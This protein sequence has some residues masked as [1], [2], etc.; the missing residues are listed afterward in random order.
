MLNA[1]D[2]ADSGIECGC[3]GPSACI[4]ARGDA[5]GFVANVIEPFLCLDNT[6]FPVSM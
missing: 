4:Q 2:F 3:N 6:P 1:I 5:F